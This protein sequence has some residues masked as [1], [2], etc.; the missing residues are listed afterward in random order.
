MFP[1]DCLLGLPWDT[2]SIPAIVPSEALHALPL[3]PVLCS[4]S[5]VPSE[6]THW[7]VE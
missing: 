3:R 5:H 7:P 6:D 1:Q 2:L 4:Q